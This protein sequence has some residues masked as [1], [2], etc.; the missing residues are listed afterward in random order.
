M[1]KTHKGRGQKREAGRN[2]AS[3]ERSRASSGTRP[4]REQLAAVPDPLAL[5][6]G[7]FTHSPV[8]YAVF[9]ADGHCLL[10]NPAY[11]EMFGAEPPPEYDLFRDELLERLGFL[12]YFRRAFAGETVQTPV[13]WYDVRQLEHIQVKD[14]N[15]IAISCSCFPLAP[16][17]AEVGHIAIAY[18]DVTAELLAREAER[19]EREKLHQLFAQ[20]PVAI[21]VLRGEELR[22]EFA[23]PLLQKL[24]GGRELLG[25]TLKEAIP[26]VSPELVS[27]HLGVLELG[28]RA[29]ANEFPLIIDYT[30]EG[31]V[32][33][34]F[35]NFIY[36]PLRDERGRVDGLMTFAFE[37]TEQVL[38]RQAVESQQ[39]WL[40]AVLDLMPMPVVMVE[41]DT[42]AISFSN[43]AADRLHGGHIPKQE[44]LLAYSER[45]HITDPAG[46]RLGA[47]EMPAAR[48][49]RGERLDGLEVVWHTDAGQHM[50]SVHSEAL[51]AMHGHPSVVVMPFLDITRLKTVERHL[52]E[53]IRA[54]D[55]FLSVASHELKT[56]LTS[57]GLRL[58]AF[59]RA[60]EANPESD[61]ARR[62][63]REVAAMRR[64]VTRLA[65]LIDG[66]LDVSRISTGRLKIHREPVDLGAL[67]QEMVAR[68]IPEAERAG[69]VLEYQPPAAS[70]VGSWDRLRMEQ[71]VSNLLS[72]ALKYGA[73]QPVHVHV[74]E[75]DGRA[76]LWVRDEGIGI[77]PEAHA[78]IFQ[79]FER[80]VSERNYGGLGLGLYVVRTLV[81][82]MGGTIRVESQPGEGATFIVELP[83]QAS[84]LEQPFTP[85]AAPA[86]GQAAS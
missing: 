80:A 51:P 3:A 55:E 83:L 86:E 75:E 4:L 7:L 38:A 49:A 24:M 45:F 35:W 69:C 50:V 77:D 53:A 78:R 31:R 8:P 59:G 40:E 32:E 82:A 36:E 22:F 46:R 14:A 19:V 52:Q 23:N 39:K 10:I 17:G 76:R 27:L 28:E 34:K 65:E 73:E 68:F 5:L 1:A 29:I 42:G 13:F 79:K 66:L 16:A 43:A 15:R 2:R 48:A 85:H 26:D 6:E 61:V 25:R 54:R 70:C 18:K 71:V 62:H 11:R 63:G 74:E 81:E 33:T 58:H 64:Q 72:N 84:E 12:P 20:A 57:L 67:V 30:G 44:S 9:T 60:I 37:V 41:P 56:P 21:N 47:D